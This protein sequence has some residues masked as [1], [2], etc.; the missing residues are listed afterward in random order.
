MFAVSTNE[1][2][3]N[4]GT[5]IFGSPPPPT[6][7]NCGH[8]LQNC[9]RF[10]CRLWLKMSKDQKNVA[11]SQ[12]FWD[13]FEQHLR[14]VEENAPLEECK[15]LY[16]HEKGRTFILFGLMKDN[17]SATDSSERTLELSWKGKN[18]LSWIRDLFIEAM[19]KNGVRTTEDLITLFKSFHSLLD[20]EKYMQNLWLDVIKT[21]Y[22]FV[23]ELKRRAPAEVDSAQRGYISFFGNASS[24][25]E[26]GQMVSKY[27]LLN[28]GRLLGYDDLPG[29]NSAHVATC[30][31]LIRCI[32]QGIY[33]SLVD[34]TKVF[35]PANPLIRRSAQDDDDRVQ[36]SDSEDDDEVAAVPVSG[37]GTAVSMGKSWNAKKEYG[38]ILHMC[39]LKCWLDLCE[40]SNTYNETTLMNAGVR[41]AVTLFNENAAKWGYGPIPDSWIPDVKKTVED[42]WVPKLLGNAKIAIGKGVRPDTAEPPTTPFLDDCQASTG[43]KNPKRKAWCTYLSL[44][45]MHIRGRSTDPTAKRAPKQSSVSV[46]TNKLPAARNSDSAGG[47]VSAVAA[48]DNGTAAASL[49]RSAEVIAGASEDAKGGTSKPRKAVKLSASAESTGFMSATLSGTSAR[50]PIDVE[51]LIERSFDKLCDTVAEAS[52]KQQEYE[53]ELQKLL[54]SMNTNMNQMNQNLS[55]LVNN[56]QPSVPVHSNGGMMMMRTPPSQTS[57]TFVRRQQISRLSGA[58]GEAALQE[59]V[60]EDLAM[61][62]QVAVPIPRAHQQPPPPRS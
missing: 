21:I 30:A 27:F 15:R 42:S 57:M 5:I 48:S 3:Y 54:V 41:A 36:D 53:T 32:C 28:V 43:A 59:L 18:V 6:S 62:Q 50:N 10:V 20:G 51:D 46:A 55:M 52:R 8:G 14:T 17:E 24:V 47:S 39:L 13:D 49:K 9:F 16:H 7:E 22:D 56:Y 38:R 26:V 1:N 44:K 35:P 61:T 45:L 2:F 33:A 31:Y 40:K 29:S 11:I 23:A 25:E 19:V 4:F 58:E 34:R 37:S 60:D 12:R